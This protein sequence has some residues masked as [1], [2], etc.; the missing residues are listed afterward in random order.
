[1]SEATALAKASRRLLPFM[2]LLYVV[3]YLDRINVGFAALTMRR[4]LG[5]SDA[6]YGLGAGIFFLGYF[7]FEIPSNLVL[8]R[9]GARRWIARIMISWGLVSSAMLFVRGPASFYALRLLLGV[10]EAGFFPGMIL[11]L[12]YWFPARARARATARFMTATAIA[13]VVGGPISV[14]LLGLDGIAGLHGW[15]W[16]FLLEGLPAVVLGIVVLVALPDGPGDARWL[17]PA[18]RAALEAALHADREV[19]APTAAHTFGAAVRDPRVW[20][21]AA[22]YFAIV[23]GFYGI[24][25]W[26]PQIVKGLSGLGD[27]AVGFLSTIPYLAAAI[28]M[29][30]VGASS[31]RRGE[32][33]GHVVA[34]VLVGATGLVWCAWLTTPVLALLALTLAAVGVW[35]ALGPFWALPVTFL[36]GSAA[37]G[38][39]ALVNSVGNLGGFVGPYVIG[40]LREATGSFAAGLLALAIGLVVGALL[41]WFLPREPVRPQTS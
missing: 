30:I 27:T 7:V 11:Y 26:T 35:S 1:M 3:A 5:F 34:A 6:V 21:L 28:A 18:E 32:R 33:R 8:Q 41:A 2:F 38:G 36:R 15:Q 10:A 29:T 14:A 9:V 40:L 12:S 4:D 31:D 24:S 39:I 17:T 16:L 19:S 13:G 23:N 20:R 22:L 25:L 37:A